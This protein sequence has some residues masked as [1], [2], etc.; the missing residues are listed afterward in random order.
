M[1]A[2]SII[3]DMLARVAPAFLA[4]ATG[5]FQLADGIHVLVKGKYIGSETPGV[6]R[7]APP[8]QSPRWQ[9]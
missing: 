9:S 1:T 4:L 8:P 2:T 3:R 5:G 6:C 7:S